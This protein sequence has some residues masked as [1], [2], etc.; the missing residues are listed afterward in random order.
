M[1]STPRLWGSSKTEPWRG[2]HLTSAWTKASLLP[3]QKSF[4]QAS[5]EMVETMFNCAPSLCS[6]PPQLDSEKKF[7]SKTSSAALSEGAHTD[8]LMSPAS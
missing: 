5:T 3:N 2:L 8:D 1:S 4:T 7:W 6:T